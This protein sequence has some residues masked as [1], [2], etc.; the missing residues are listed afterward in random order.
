MELERIYNVPL[1]REWLKVPLY[2]RAKKATLA[3]RQFLE[4]HMKSEDVFIGKHL[5]EAVW[6]HGMR[7]PPH[8]VKVTCV[9]DDAG[10]VRAE[11]FGVKIE[12]PLPVEKKE[13]ALDKVK[14]A[15][16]KKDEKKVGFIE[17]IDSVIE[18]K[19]KEDSEEVVVPAQVSDSVLSAVEN[20]ADI[21]NVVKPKKVAKPKVSKK[22]VK[23]Q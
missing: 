5:N 11:L 14:A 17:K 16:G 3:L 23:N 1:R 13:G 19:D 15:L 4:Q 6:A 20:V 18:K 22:E 8:H 10:V 7:N 21:K 12:Q 2:K 9:K